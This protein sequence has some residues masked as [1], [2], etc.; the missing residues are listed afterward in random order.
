MPIH[1]HVD[2]RRQYQLPEEQWQHY[3]TF[4]I[5]PIY[6]SLIDCRGGMLQRWS[7]PTRL[8]TETFLANAT[9]RRRQHLNRVE[10]FVPKKTL[11]TNLI[12]LTT[13]K[14]TLGP[15]KMPNPETAVFFVLSFD[16]ALRTSISSLDLKEKSLASA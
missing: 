8:L 5:T 1:Q 11:R 14:T 10:R 15:E 7:S 3:L 9:Q 13:P 2:L 16:S 12:C 6:S 4:D